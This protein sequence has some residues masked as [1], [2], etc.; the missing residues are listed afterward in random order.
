M[1]TDITTADLP[2]RLTDRKRQAVIDAAIAEF[3]ASGFEATSM[4]KIAATAGVSKRT[5]YNH[6]PSKDE[7]F[8]QI[9]HQLWDSSAAL[10]AIPYRPGEPLRPQLMK[11]LGQ[12]MALLQ[13]AYFIDLARVAIA[14]AIHSPQRA[15][16]MV[17]RLNDKEEGVT[18]WLRA[19][20]ADGQLQAAGDPMLASHWLQG[21]LK[22][23]AFWPQVTLGQ[24]LLEPAAQQLVLTMAVDSFLA[25]CA[26]AKT[27]E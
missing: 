10:L 4:D 9:L 7:L 5:V 27:T 24:P 17:A 23:F 14:E 26:A 6:F 21:Q 11:L 18:S 22:T 20:Q 15:Q 8:T 12:K 19:A 13:D 16:D 1:S 3:R 2:L 25:Y